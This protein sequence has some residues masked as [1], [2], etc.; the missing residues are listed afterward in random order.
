MIVI[1]NFKRLC[2]TSE[3]KRDFRARRYFT[4]QNEK[5]KTFLTHQPFCGSHININRKKQ[6]CNKYVC[7]PF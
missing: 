3:N 7:I 2:L 6:T 5:Q 4:D 1:D